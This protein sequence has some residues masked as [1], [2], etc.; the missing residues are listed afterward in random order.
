MDMK[1]AVSVGEVGGRRWGGSD[2]SKQYE[3][4]HWASHAE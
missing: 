2:V 4:M 3:D 1:E